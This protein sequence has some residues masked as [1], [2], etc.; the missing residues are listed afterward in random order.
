MKIYS[1]DESFSTTEPIEIIDISDMAITVVKQ[2]EVQ[3]GILSVTTPHTTTSIM[4][5]EKCEQ[6]Q[7][8]MMSFLKKLVP[9]TNYKHDREP[10]DLRPNAHSHL[11]SMVLGHSVTIP[12]VNGEP[13]FGGWQRLF[14]VELDGP[15]SKRYFKLQIIGS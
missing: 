6:L 2:S 14:F 8:D 7:Q 12:V 15:R 10:R 11:M 1:K 4:V 3:N 5:N 9:S 13:E